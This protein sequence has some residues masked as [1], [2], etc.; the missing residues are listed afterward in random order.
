MMMFLFAA[1]L[2]LAGLV[3]VTPIEGECVRLVP[4][5]QKEAMR[6]PTLADRIRFLKAK[7]KDEKA[8]K[9]DDC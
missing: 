3:P 5:G 2:L 7:R 4:D 6:L 9:S 1:S 8:K